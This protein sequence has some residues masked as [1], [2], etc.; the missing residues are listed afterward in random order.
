MIAIFPAISSCAASGD[1]ERLSVL[2]RDYFGGEG[3][4][5][6]QISV[7]VVYQNAGIPLAQLSVDGIG[8]L[9]AKDQSGRFEITAVTNPHGGTYHGRFLMAHMLGHYFL[10][11]QPFIARGDWLVSGFRESQCAMQRYAEGSRDV[12]LSPFELKREMQADLFAAALLM[13]K[14][15]VQKAMARL[16]DTAKVAHLFGVSTQAMT[17]R[18]EGLAEGTQSPQNF[19]AA[20]SQL[21]EGRP[22]SVLKGDT[23]IAK[24]ARAYRDAAPNTG[25]S[26]EPAEANALADAGSMAPTALGRG[27]DRIRELAKRLDKSPSKR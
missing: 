2:I 20:E 23:Q 9:V 8:A 3:K 11:V 12:S 22:G 27:M 26:Q 1:M 14:G 25:K 6:P 24:G 4:F 21:R 7:E 5:A 16:A 13:P 10:H 18:L 19:L 17:T 15:M